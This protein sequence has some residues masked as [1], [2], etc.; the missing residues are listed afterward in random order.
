MPDLPQYADTG[1]AAATE[2]GGMSGYFDRG[3]DLICA[4]CGK[5]MHPTF[6]S[7]ERAIRLILKRKRAHK[8]W[9]QLRPYPCRVSGTYHVGHYTPP[10]P[11]K[12]RRLK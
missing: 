4:P 3:Q 12:R 8:D 5:V 1:M 9:R 10:R 6:R 7:A 2:G 11:R